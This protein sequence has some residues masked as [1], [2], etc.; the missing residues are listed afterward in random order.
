MKYPYIFYESLIPLSLW[1]WYV[2]PF[3]LAWQFNFINIIAA[4]TRKISL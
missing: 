3:A 1:M 2:N 4:N